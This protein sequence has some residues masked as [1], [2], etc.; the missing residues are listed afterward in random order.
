MRL[1]PLIDRLLPNSSR[2]YLRRYNAGFAS[3]TEPGMRVLDAGAGE[4]PYR[5]L[6]SHAV[7]ESADFELV[8]KPYARSTYVCDLA[9]IP[10]EDERFDR[11]I[12][13]QVL[14]HLPEPMPVLRELHRTL[15][16]GGAMICTCPFFYE[17]H[18]KPYDFYRY[19]QFAHRYLFAKAGFEIERLEWMEGYFGTIAYQLQGM[20]LHIPGSPGA[21]FH[22]PWWPVVFWPLALFV[23]AAAAL[24]AANFYRM[25]IACKITDRGYPKNYVLILRKPAAIAPAEQGDPALARDPFPV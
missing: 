18:E 22:R 25:D 8:D 13:N 19:T 20:A 15:K 24:L 7:Y 2:V 10:V 4:Q 5:S 11:I 21:Y 23:K 17:E 3:E 14:E 1:R 16:P 12:F 6:F 9:A